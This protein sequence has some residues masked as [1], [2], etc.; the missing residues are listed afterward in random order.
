M[1][2]RRAA[3][4]IIATT[5]Q[6]PPACVFE[7][8]RHV[9]DMCPA[10]EPGPRGAKKPSALTVAWHVLAVLAALPAGGPVNRWT[11]T[12]GEGIR[13]RAVR[14]SE[15]V[16]MA[17]AV[18]IT[19]RP[20]AEGIAVAA[21]GL[22]LIGALERLFVRL[23]EPNFLDTVTTGRTGGPLVNKPGV[24]LSIHG[25]AHHSFA[26]LRFRFRNGSTIKTIYRHP[27]D[28]D[29]PA[30]PLVVRLDLDTLTLIRLAAVARGIADAEAPDFGALPAGHIALNDDGSVPAGFAPVAAPP[31][32]VNPF[33]DLV[34]RLDATNPNS[35]RARAR[36][37]AR[38][39]NGNS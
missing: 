36:A 25:G 32:I 23:L 15:L 33:D 6:L 2:T 22:P 3:R 13:A 24:S 11:G 35:P 38:R 27:A 19:G 14:W 34:E 30:P 20:P 17:G 29:K 9:A 21:S 1:S 8:V 4:S 18:Q 12:R 16:P 5:L 39:L 31:G 28:E 37:R 26:G 10:D 7:A